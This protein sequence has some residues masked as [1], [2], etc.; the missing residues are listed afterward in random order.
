[1]VTP[2]ADALA[3]AEAA[4]SAPCGAAEELALAPASETAAEAAAPASEAA[5]PASEAAAPASEAAA[6]LGCVAPGATLML[7]MRVSISVTAICRGPSNR[8]G[9]T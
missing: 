2:E 6:E 5:A 7:S 3:A 9:R 8:V 1:M 4:A